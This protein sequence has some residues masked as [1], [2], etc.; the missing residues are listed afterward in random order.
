MKNYFNTTIILLSLIS[1]VMANI[2]LP[3]ISQ[4][5]RDLANKTTKSKARINA[6]NVKKP[7]ISKTLK[8]SIN[9][10]IHQAEQKSKS[11]QDSVKVLLNKTINNKAWKFKQAQLIK[12][13]NKDLGIDNDKQNETVFGHRLYL[14]V[15]SSM[16]KEKMRAYARQLHQ[17][18]NAQMLLRGF[19][20][21]G[22]KMRPTMAYIKSMITKHE[23]C[24]HPNCVTYKANVNI[25]PVLFQRYNIT[26]VPT[27]VYVDELSG[28]SYCS[29]GNT[30]IVNAS[31]VHKFIGLAP[32]KYMI[33]E[34][35]EN[36]KLLKLERLLEL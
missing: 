13:L 25:D 24:N 35:A 29:E 9:I 5:M 14:F 12:G 21:G 10:L 19:I 32:F 20:G 27:L 3:E 4:D 16:P 8:S 30:D 36:T 33:S 28:A 23:S 26:K 17:Y 7:V 31:G 18:P 1:P 6:F 15:S 11:Y 2:T 22:K 34:L